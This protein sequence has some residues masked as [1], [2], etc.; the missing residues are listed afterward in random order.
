MSRI[1]HMSH[2][3]NHTWHW[4]GFDMFF[5]A[6]ASAMHH[7]LPRLENSSR[8]HTDKKRE[9]KGIYLMAPYHL[10]DIYS[11]GNMFWVLPMD[12]DI[13]SRS[14]VIAEQSKHRL[15]HSLQ[16]VMHWQEQ[17]KQGKTLQEISTS[18]K[19]ELTKLKK[20]LVLAI[21]PDTIKSRILHQQGDESEWSLRYGLKFA[22]KIK[23][24][25]ILIDTF[26][27]VDQ[28]MKWQK[29]GKSLRWIAQ[30][31]GLSYVRVS[32]LIKLGEIQLQKR[33]DF[34]EEGLSIRQIYYTYI[35]C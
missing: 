15:S 17:I 29:V 4:S 12:N 18:N 13:L 35:S 34:I 22:N 21:L 28:W 19:I 24:R 26:K 25:Q 27:Q 33:N 9:P 8:S 20:L 14:Q 31:V 6:R 30:Q 32:K 10:R 1:S 11:S 23:R 2:S 7:P 16:Q 3:Q 5:V